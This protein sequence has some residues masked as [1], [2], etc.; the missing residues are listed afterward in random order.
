[1]VLFLHNRYRTTGGEE[2]VVDDLAWLVSERL[3]EDT[4]V[5]AISSAALSLVILIIAIWA[6]F[7][8][9]GHHSG[10]APSRNVHRK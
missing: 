5:L 4:R 3:G 7:H 2:Q 1:M 6:Y 10:R 9:H 8:S